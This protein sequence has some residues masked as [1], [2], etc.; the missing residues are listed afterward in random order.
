MKRWKIRKKEN[1]IKRFDVLLLFKKYFVLGDSIFFQKLCT[2]R[3]GSKRRAWKSSFFPPA[4]LQLSFEGIIFISNIFLWLLLLKKE[5]KN[6]FHDK[7]NRASAKSKVTDLV[8]NSKKIIEIS[9][10]EETYQ[11]PDI[12]FRNFYFFF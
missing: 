4:I 3:S 9:K 8:D 5:T 12:N 11:K 2:Y 1:F 7:V 10:H 6:E